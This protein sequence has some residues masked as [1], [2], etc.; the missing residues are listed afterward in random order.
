MEDGLRSKQQKGQVEQKRQEQSKRRSSPLALTL[1]LSRALP[2]PSRADNR[3]HAQE[4][5]RPSPHDFRSLSNSLLTTN[6][7]ARAPILLILAVPPRARGW[8]EFR[9]P[10]KRIWIVHCPSFVSFSS[11]PS[12]VQFASFSISLVLLNGKMQNLL[13]NGLTEVETKRSGSEG[14]ARVF[15]SAELDS[16]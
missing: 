6:H 7:R 11:L 3:T 12:L 8:R 16:E 5:R 10:N 4:Q 2:S 15:F 1:S 14:S 9:P 13:E